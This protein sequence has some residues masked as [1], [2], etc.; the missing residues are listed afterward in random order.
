MGTVDSSGSAGARSVRYVM[1][2]IDAPAQWDSAARRR[3]EGLRGL[4]DERLVWSTVAA[5]CVGGAM[6]LIGVRRRIG[7]RMRRAA[8][9]PPVPAAR[10]AAVARTHFADGGGYVAI[11][12]VV[13]WA[14]ASPAS[15]ILPGHVLECEPG[16]DGHT[17][18]VVVAGDSGSEEHCA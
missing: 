6:M 13:V 12:D 2:D 10:V 7:S 3:A 8:V 11:G 14:S 9:E 17:V 18:R 4:M 16:G 5:L 1:T 15:R